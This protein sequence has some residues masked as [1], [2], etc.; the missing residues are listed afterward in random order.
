MTAIETDAANPHGPP[1]LINFKDPKALLEGTTDAL[2]LSLQDAATAW[3][4]ESYD[5]MVLAS[6][7]LHLAHKALKDGEN[8]IAFTATERG[9]GVLARQVPAAVKQPLGHSLR[10]KQGLALARAGATEKARTVL[11]ALEEEGARTPEIQGGLARLQRDFAQKTED[12]KERLACWRKAYTIALKAA[13][14][15]PKSYYN[16]G[17]A[18]NAA[19]MT[20]NT[21][22][23]NLHADQARLI[24]MEER[25]DKKKTPTSED[26]FWHEGTLAEAAL[27]RGELAQA[28][29]HYI[30][31]SELSA[32]KH[33]GDVGACLRVARMLLTQLGRDCSEFDDCFALPP[34]AIFSGHLF[35]STDRKSA[36]LPFSAAEAVQ[37]RIKKHL[38]RQRFDMAFCSMSWGAD[39]LFAEE[40][41]K[42]DKAK[43]HI[44]LPAD[45]G[46]TAKHCIARKAPKEQ[47]SEWKN[48]FR[49]VL[50]RAA[51]V[52]ALPL[53][54][55]Q[56]SDRDFEY[57]NELIV[58][59]A[60]AKAVELDR[61]VIPVLVWDRVNNPDKGGTA[62][63]HRL[64]RDKQRTKP[65][66]IRPAP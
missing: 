36:R 58:G 30:A 29:K 62:G 26:H 16:A 61:E 39:L 12:P 20:G 34:I 15:N 2:A 4:V 40:F 63:F 41:V 38:D 14:D 24:V 47:R 43:L 50:E 65:L 33:A 5:G 66:I 8:Y 52:R 23:A 60:L 55:L 46:T 22:K 37:Q 53:Q 42:R 17:Q 18:A 27:V 19:L 51:T 48:R 35:D 13:Q 54:G 44:V 11:H 56:P 32:G 28:R 64:W 49:K 59:L 1:M 7:Y 10:Q 45:P 9:L 57:L 25:A 3:S 6:H 31:F 21:S